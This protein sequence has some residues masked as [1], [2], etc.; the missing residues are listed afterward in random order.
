MSATIAPETTTDRP[1][2]MAD[3]DAEAVGA[4]V[5]GHLLAARTGYPV[6]IHGDVWRITEVKPIRDGLLVTI[7]DPDTG[8]KV[9]TT[10]L[11]AAHGIEV[12]A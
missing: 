12:R 9:Y 1:R 2:I 5:L 3:Q 7:E 6:T 11:I 10:A 8:R 4:G